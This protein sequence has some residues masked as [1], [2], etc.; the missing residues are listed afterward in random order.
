MHKSFPL[1]T[2]STNRKWSIRWQ[3]H[4]SFRVRKF[5]FDKHVAVGTWRWT[6]S[7]ATETPGEVCIIRENNFVRQ[8]GQD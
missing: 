5:T 8:Q 3:N 2:W 4:E 6:I 7:V 1:T